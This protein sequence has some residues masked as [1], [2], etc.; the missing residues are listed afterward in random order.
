MAT[1]PYCKQIFTT[2][3]NSKKFFK[4]KLIENYFLKRCK[5]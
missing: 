3:L 2:V 5:G 1:C 4:E